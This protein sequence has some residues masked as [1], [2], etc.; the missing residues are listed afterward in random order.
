MQVLMKREQLVTVSAGFA[1]LPPVTNIKIYSC[2]N[3]Q[4]GEHRTLSFENPTPTLLQ[5]KS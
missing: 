5:K 2:V 1:H 4:N 3:F